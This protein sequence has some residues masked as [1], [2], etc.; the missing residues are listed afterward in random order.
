MLAVVERVGEELARLFGAV[1]HDAV[2]KVGHVSPLTIV[3]KYFADCGELSP[4][5]IP[6][7]HDTLKS[8]WRL[9]A[10]YL[11]H[12][13]PGHR[14]TVALLPGALC[15]CF[16]AHFVVSL[17]FVVISFGFLPV[18]SAHRCSATAT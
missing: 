4:C 10:V 14:E 16:A 15:F 1:A 5:A 8:A 18:A 12:L 17:Y 2:A 9:A 11:A 3:V 13:A 6:F 7:P